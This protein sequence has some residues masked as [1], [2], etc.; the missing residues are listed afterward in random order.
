M[1]EKID[2][3]WLPLATLSILGRPPR[4]TFPLLFLLWFCH[5][6]VLADYDNGMRYAFVASP[7]TRS[8]SIIDLHDKRLAES[9]Q[10]REIPGEIEASNRLKALIVAH[11]GAKK[12]TLVDLT[13]SDLEQI[14]FKLELT[15]DVIKLNP[16]GDTV[17]VYDRSQKIIEI[18]NLHRRQILIRVEDVINGELLTF[19]RDGQQIFWVDRTTGKLNA[20]NLWGKRQAVALTEDGSGLSAM[21]RSVDGSMGFISDAA[22]GKVYVVNLRRMKLLKSV[23]VGKGAQRAWGTADGQVMIVPNYDDDTITAI[24]TFTFEP[25]YTLKTIHQPLTINTGWLDTTAAVFGG[26]GEI[27]LMNLTSGKIVKRLQIHGNPQAG[28]VSSNSRLLVLPI[29]GYGDLF[30]IDMKSLS[31]DERIIDLPRDIGKAS[32]AISNNLCH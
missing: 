9:I 13:D 29:A 21:T 12:L 3:K 14:D 27:A 32:L 11:P 16:V 4:L 5:T 6:P 23:R 18:Y 10:L 7:N 19:N 30:I 17:A 8:I 20:S 26:S 22:A 15:P 31:L 24:S 25:K 28:V 2:S 1:I